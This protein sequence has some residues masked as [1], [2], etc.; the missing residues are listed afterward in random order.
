MNFSELTP[1]EKLIC[2]IFGE[3]YW[4]EGVKHFLSDEGRKA[5]NDVLDE[6]PTKNVGR[7]Q[8]TKAVRERGV[9][10]VKVLRLRF[11]FEPRTDTE[12]TQPYISDAR[13]IKETTVYFGVTTN[14]I[15]QI[16]NK[17]L[18]MLRHP[19]YICKLK[20]YLEKGP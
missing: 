20:P 7:G 4:S 13:N 18:R 2:A 8:Q 17:T 16:E 6:F 1:E 11:G 5:V 10:G 19:V 14:R 15:R 3:P 12:K 9:R